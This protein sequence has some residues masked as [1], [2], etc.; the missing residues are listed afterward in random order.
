MV[1]GKALKNGAEL[2]KK[3][4]DVPLLE[5]RVLLE[6]VL[7]A[8]RLTLIKESGSE[9]KDNDREAFMS[10]IFQRLSG[11]PIAYITG[12]KEFM[13]LDFFVNADVL[14]PRPDT[15]TL[16][17][18][19]IGTGKRKILDIGTGSGAIAVSLAKYIADS[20]VSAADI[21]PDALAVAEKNARANKAEINF[22]LLDILNDEIG[23]KYDMIVSNPPYIKDSVIPTLDKTVRAFEPRLALSGGEDGLKFYRKIAEKAPGALYGGGILAFEI[24]YDQAHAV[25]EIMAKSFKNIQ[26]IKDLAGCDRVVTGEIR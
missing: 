6:H 13:G 2:L 26:I 21:S 24:G 18:Y 19:A 25:S 5:S 9:L 8:D 11:K 15:E 3:V 23:G 12:H 7:S 22:L 14:I 17:E 1:I 16:V 10:L 20:E 4:S